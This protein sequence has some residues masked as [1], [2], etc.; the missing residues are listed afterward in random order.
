MMPCCDFGLHVGIGIILVLCNQSFLG[1]STP[2]VA[3]APC[4]AA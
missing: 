3:L 4:S 2:K 1:Q